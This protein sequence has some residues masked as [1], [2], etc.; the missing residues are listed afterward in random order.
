MPL[1]EIHC[2]AFPIT[3]A[4]GSRISITYTAEDGTAISTSYMH[5]DSIL[6]GV[7]IDPTLGPDHLNDPMVYIRGAYEKIPP[8]TIS[9]S[10]KV[11]PV[12]LSHAV[13]NQKQ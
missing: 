4:G 9:E 2:V 6:D 7:N 1:A 5:L 10:A 11:M 8:S 3:N 12:I 13:T